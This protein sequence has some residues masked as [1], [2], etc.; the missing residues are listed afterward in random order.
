MKTAVVILSDPRGGDEALG[1]LWNGLAV[2]HECKERG[3]D[4]TIL[5]QG[6]GTRW[7]GELRK[8]AHPAHGLWSEVEDRVA[9]VSCGCAEVFGAAGEARESGLE[10]L[11]EYALPGTPGIAS[12]R[13]LASRGYSVLTF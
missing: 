2:A 6:A 9:G 3:D 13:S 4:V 12:L 5:F 10:L 8:A 1:R 7:A 11:K